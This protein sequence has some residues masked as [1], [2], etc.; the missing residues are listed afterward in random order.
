MS[1]RKSSFEHSPNVL[2]AEANRTNLSEKFQQLQEEAAQQEFSNRLDEFVIHVQTQKCVSINLSSLSLLKFFQTGEYLNIHELIQR[3]MR[4]AESTAYYRRRCEVED[5]LGFIGEVKTQIYYGCLNT[6][7]LGA[8]NFG[9]FCLVLKATTEISRSISFLEQNSLSY[10]KRQYP[11][12]K[13][14]VALRDNVH[15]LAAIKH[16]DAIKQ[17][18]IPF[19]TPDINF[20][21][22][23]YSAALRL[24]E[25]IEAHIWGKITPSDISE[26]RLPKKDFDWVVECLAAE[27]KF[28]R[29]TPS[30]KRRVRSLAKAIQ[31]VRRFSIPIILM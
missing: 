18:E 4:K 23:F 31:C 19:S 26:M 8:C 2:I 30:E 6:G 9:L 14:N 29:L 1:H 12:L 20:L 11:Q 27:D 5:A 7:N 25:F 15:Q 22:L 13:L 3:G 17:R 28:S 10:R 21:V 24:S 16:Q